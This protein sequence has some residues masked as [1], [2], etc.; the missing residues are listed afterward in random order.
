MKKSLSLICITLIVL[1]LLGSAFACTDD[2]RKLYF[3][4]T[5]YKLYL[6]DDNPSI[7]PEVFTR[8]RGNDYVLSVSNPTIA[9]VEGNTVTALREGIVTLTATSGDMTATAKLIVYVMRDATNED[10]ADE[11]DDDDD[12]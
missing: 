11:D 1:L 10:M 9:K 8:P 7:T 12:D 5:T 4:E 3:T 2:T 6:S